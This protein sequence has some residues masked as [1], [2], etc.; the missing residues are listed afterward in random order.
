LTDRALNKT[1]L[2]GEHRTIRT[3]IAIAVFVKT[4]SLING[5]QTDPKL[6]KE[7]LWD[8]AACLTQSFTT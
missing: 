2:S 1:M 7:M 6:Q 3:V 4:L 5:R 8:F